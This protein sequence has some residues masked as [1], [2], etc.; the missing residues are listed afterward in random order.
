M[1]RGNRDVCQSIVHRLVADL[2]GEEADM[3]FCNSVPVDSAFYAELT[4]TSD[5]KKR[6]FETD[7]NLHWQM[8][9]PPTMEEFYGRMSKKTRDNLR[10]Y[11]RRFEKRYPK[12][13]IRIF[14]VEDDQHA[15]FDDMEKVA[16]KTYQRG[17]GVGFAATPE[18]RAL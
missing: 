11:A 16:S 18:R 14:S 17:M 3:L 5:F 15:A 9:V 2:R 13:E 8:T 4:A 10:Y 1:D 7:R 12:H 6:G